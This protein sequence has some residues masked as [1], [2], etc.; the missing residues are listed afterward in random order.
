[1]RLL[2]SQKIDLEGLN[3]FNFRLRQNLLLPMIAL[4]YAQR[5]SFYHNPTAKRLLEI[6]ERKKTN[7]CVSVDVTTKDSVLSIVDAVGPS[8]CMV[9]VTMHALSVT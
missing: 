7:L 2:L 3:G 5:S 1:M 4:T 6:I 9:K 8:V